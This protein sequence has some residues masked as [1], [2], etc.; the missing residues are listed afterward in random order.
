MA[1]VRLPD[2]DGSVELPFSVPASTL[3][4]RHVR[5]A[6]EERARTALGIVRRQMRAGGHRLVAL[7]WRDT[8]AGVTVE[9]VFTHEDGAA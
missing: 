4:R 2:L 3:I 5:A 9:M 7:S 8:R 6:D 1:A